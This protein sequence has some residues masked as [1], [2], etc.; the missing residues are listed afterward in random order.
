MSTDCLLSS[1]LSFPKDSRVYRLS[2][3]GALDFAFLSQGVNS[4]AELVPSPQAYSRNGALRRWLG[5]NEE[6]IKVIFLRYFFS[7]ILK[8]V[9]LDELCWYFNIQP[10]L[11]NLA[12][13][14]RNWSKITKKVSN[15]QYSIQKIKSNYTDCTLSLT[16]NSHNKF[17]IT[18]FLKII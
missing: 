10:W 8:T 12:F 3:N 17:N 14:G 2:V 15:S 6:E 7:N 18:M 9:S 5:D 4:R 11:F 1:P 16:V 13:S